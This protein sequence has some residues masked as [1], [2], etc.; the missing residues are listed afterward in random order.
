LANAALFAKAL[1]R[2][3]VTA[4][5]TETAQKQAVADIFQEVDEEVRR[6]Q[7]QRLWQRYGRYA[8]GGAVVLLLGIGGFIGWQQYSEHRAATRAQQFADAIALTGDADPAKSTAAFQQLAQGSDGIAAAARFRLA[9]AKVQAKDI[10]GAVATYDSISADA[11]LAQPLRDAA[12]L[13]AALQL[14][15]TAEPADLIKRLEPL[16]AATNPWRFSAL[17]LTALAAHR[18]GDIA[19]A[20]TIYTLLADDLETPSDL[21]GRAA[22][23]LE[24]LKEK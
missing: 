10:T 14:A 17:E 19:K 6:E 15:D 20:R 24:A 5:F 21:R 7:W 9:A 4:P 23:M 22:E 2:R 3:Y 16:T 13:L 12:T 18:A 1:G 8:T 11:S